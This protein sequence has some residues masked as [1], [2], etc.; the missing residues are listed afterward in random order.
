MQRPKICLCLTCPTIAENLA[1]LEKYRNWVDVVELRVD[2]LTKDERLYIRQFPGQA[3]IP[4]ILTIRRKIDGG[5]FTEGEASRTTL[6]ARALS[7][8]DQDTRKNFAYIDL[9]DDYHVPCLQDAAF[10][11]G[12]RVIRSFHDMNGTIPDIAGRMAKM[13]ITGFEIPKIAV[14]PHTLTD[15]TSLFKQA[16]Q[17]KDMEHILIAMGSLGLPS[18]ILSGKLH[19]FMTY[20][21]P[22]ETISKLAEIGQIDPVTLNQ[23]YNFRNI[24]DSTSL[25]GITGYPLKATG[26]PLIHNSG[27]R[28]HGMNAVYI[29]VRA[30]KIEEALEFA[31]A[32]GIQ[33]LSVT[34]PHKE[35]IIPNLQQISEEVGYIGACNTAVKKGNE[36]RGY[37]TD[38]GGLSKALLEF[39]E[40]KNL[41]RI[42]IGI[43]GAGGAARAAA[44]IVKDLRGKACIF[45]RTVS[46]ARSLAEHYG[47]KWASLS[48]DSLDLLEEYS[49]LIIQTTSIGL[50]ISEE[51]KN[52]PE[53]D[54]IPFYTFHG[55]EAVY[56][57]IYSPEK[58]P[59]LE[60]AEKAHCRI[61]NGRTM[62]EYQAHEQFEIFTGEPYEWPN[63]DAE[64]TK[65]TGWKKHN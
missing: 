19:S 3:K 11:F 46:K 28:S 35:T 16:E 12:T 23:V 64:R 39:M 10:A 24:D 45:N 62:L 20:T 37:N 54:P 14:M 18:R 57:M 26:S 52:K 2:F 65:R 21:S 1:V 32:V 5:N 59:V 7:F 29:P 36:W 15:V 38:A 9:E 27:Y 48:A 51:E 8:A 47:F 44:Q 43:L 30:Q 50:G 4:C 61:C 17:L 42:K 41:S 53:H 58:T 49:E 63:I 6:L 25:F 34:V 33:G 55:H 56:D 31:E 22:V 60:R 40:V 13:R